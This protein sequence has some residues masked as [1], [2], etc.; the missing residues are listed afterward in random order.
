MQ[1]IKD[2]DRDRIENK[3]MECVGDIIQEETLIALAENA[4]R[5]EEC[6]MDAESMDWQEHDRIFICGDCGHCQ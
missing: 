2:L 1:R 3:A 5:C 4:G 6:D